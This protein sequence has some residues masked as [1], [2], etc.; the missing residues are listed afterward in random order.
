M[1]PLCFILMPS[2]QPS[3]GDGPLQDF[4]AAYAEL[5]QPAVL[6]AGLEPVRP[7]GALAESLFNQARLTQ[8]LDNFPG[9]QRLKTDV[10]RERVQYA[11][12][13][14]D[15][16]AAARGSGVAAVAALEQ[17]LGDIGQADA[18][19]VLDLFLSYRAVKAWPAMIALVSR[20]APALAA[21]VLVREQ[22]AFA[23]NRA[24]HGEEAEAL[25]Q[26]LIAER[27]PSSETCALL[28]RVYKDRWDAAVRQGDADL[29]RGLLEQAI[30][31]YLQG[32]EADWRDAYPGINAVTLMELRDAPDPRQAALLPVVRYAVERRITGGAADYWDHATRLELAALARDEAGMAAAL[33]A[34]LAH[35]HETWEPETTARN[36][37]LIAEA[38][39]ARGA[40]DAGL[41]TIIAALTARAR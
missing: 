39:R 11:Q 5:I 18:A 41:A 6:A 10:F 24:G 31:A 38:R 23:L 29:A 1:T 12:D 26:T 33:A 15:K 16:L 37:R 13:I 28:G 2:G 36:L 9:I 27:G 3:S 21:T 19:V 4:D 25:L 20:M 8:V 40:E 30:A 32:F 35:A 14:R 17:E 22:L 34:A 7:L